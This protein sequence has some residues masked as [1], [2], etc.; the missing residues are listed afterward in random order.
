MGR[1]AKLSAA[2]FEG[3]DGEDIF[4]P[5]YAGVR[6]HVIAKAVGG[7]DLSVHIRYETFGQVGSR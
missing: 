5:H 1:T 6:S 4:T 3:R 7:L 2:Q